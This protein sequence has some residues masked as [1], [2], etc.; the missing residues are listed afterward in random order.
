MRRQFEY[1]TPAVQRDVILFAVH[2][3]EACESVKVLFLITIPSSDLFRSRT[4]PRHRC[5]PVLSSSSIYRESRK[6]ISSDTSTRS[7]VERASCIKNNIHLSYTYT[8]TRNSA[9]RFFLRSSIDGSRRNIIQNGRFL[10]S[11]LGC[12]F[13]RVPNN[14]YNNNKNK[15]LL[16]QGFDYYIRLSFE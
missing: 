15:A 6:T 16:V 4:N 2:V 5:V 10:P 12:V 8:H 13:R 9:E 3:E 7:P 11:P 14:Y 1:F